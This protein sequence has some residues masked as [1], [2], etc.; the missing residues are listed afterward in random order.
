MTTDA[1]RWGLLSTARINDAIIPALRA[2]DRA[3]L[4]AV[5]SRDLERASAYAD[6]HDIGRAYGSYEELLADPGVD[7]VYNPLPNHLH[8]PWTVRACEAGKHVLCEKPLA[9]SLAEVDAITGA[10]RANDVVVAEAFM[11]RHHPQTLRVLELVHTGAIGEVRLV[12]GS[13]SFPLTNPGDVRLDPAM[14]GGATWDVGV[15]P[16]SFARLAIGSAPLEARAWRHDGATGVDLS[17][18]AMIRFA[19]GA[20][21]QLDCSF[22]EPERMNLEIVGSAGVIVLPEPFKPGRRAT[23]LLGPSSSDLSP[24]VVEA[25]Q[26]LYRYEVEDLTDNVIG[27]TEPR[28]PLADSRA[29]VATALAVLESGARDGEPV[30]VELVTS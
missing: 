4:V 17:C 8:A 20:I 13:F 19:N 27:A 24:T 23:I 3:E 2:A 30:T 28:I 9:C 25:D 29:N 14:G 1:L 10:A 12:R 26:E 7:V 22:E 21:A 16:I 18:R 15:Y 6:S 11:Y 5:A